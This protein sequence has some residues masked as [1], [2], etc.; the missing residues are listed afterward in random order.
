MEATELSAWLCVIEKEDR[1][2]AIFRAGQ[3]LVPLAEMKNGE[4][5]SN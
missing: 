4:S 3:I 2:C 1:V 5:A